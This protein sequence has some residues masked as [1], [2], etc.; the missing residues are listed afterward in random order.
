MFEHGTYLI[1]LLLV[2]GSLVLMDF[3][4]KL[5]LFA[6]FA[7]AWRTLLCSILFFVVWDACGIS[8]HI[9]YSGHSRFMLNRYLA[10]NFPIEEI[11]FLLILS[12]L[13]L[14]IWEYAG[15]YNV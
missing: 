5:V 7:A 4:W 10:P 6:N 3:R 11:F 13:P 15:R 1:T 8:L 2:I 9:F 14:L 12:Y